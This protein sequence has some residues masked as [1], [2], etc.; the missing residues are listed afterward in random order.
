MRSTLLL[1]PALAAAA[2]P[3]VNGV[4]TSVKVS[5]Y[6]LQT[7]D[8]GSCRL[9]GIDANSDNFKYYASLPYKDT[10]VN[11]A[12]AQCIKVTESTKGTSLTAYVLDVCTGC[13]S[14]T[15]KLSSAALTSLAIDANA[16]NGTVSYHFTT[17]PTSFLTGNVKACLMEGASNTYNP[18]QFY[19]SKK[20]IKSA[21][22]SGVA[23]SQ[24]KDAFF[25]YSNP[26]NAD[27][28]SWSQNVEVT[29]T[30]TDDETKTGTFSFSGG[31][32]CA[33]STFQFSA[34]STADA[35]NSGGASS[36]SSSAGSNTGIV[37]GAVLGA[38]GALMLI[39]GSIFFIRR[40]RASRN[41]TSS[42]QEDKDNQYL[43]PTAKPQQRSPERPTYAA[44]SSI[45]N[46]TTGL[47]DGEPESPMADFDDARTPPASN[48][49]NRDAY[50]SQYQYQPAATSQRY[51]APAAAAPAPYHQPQAAAA[52]SAPRS[53]YFAAPSFSFSKPITNDRQSTSSNLRASTAR[54]GPTFPA[55]VLPASHS[56]EEDDDVDRSSF[57]IDDWRQTE[58]NK[59]RERDSS[60]TNDMHAV[61][62]YSSESP[63]ATSQVTSPQSY[64]RATALRRTTS[65]PM[66]RP[67]L[68]Y[69]S[70]PAPQPAA[71]HQR[72]LSDSFGD[73][74][75]DSFSSDSQS[76]G[77][78]A[79]EVNP[80]TGSFRES[81]TGY[82]RES[83]GILGYPY[84]KKPS[85][86]NSSS[87]ITELQ[88]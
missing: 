53:S 88:L 75:R 13:A 76:R 8:T 46:S 86:R 34:A 21:N 83:L 28:T 50:G 25:F 70:V 52:S 29:L 43:S 66:E 48:V 78:G 32:G 58:E 39:I 60:M 81:S 69:S 4:A 84:A 1:L 16:N 37:I 56:R 30:S 71:T 3:V 41:T 12:C 17:C 67:T 72:Q 59:A 23:A 63:Y 10:T 18:L 49:A 5:Q 80:N 44:D 54:T 65:K 55:P 68:R 77:Q 22:I 79:N 35:D 27:A 19:N 7:A 57:D 15:I 36:T 24:Q 11:Q 6:V 61:A 40:R 73:T 9:K 26:K 47:S 2:A 14:G 51:E 82:S 42:P 87:S 33:T 64:V 85:G 20:V 31:S 45:H 38:V 74:D 62:P